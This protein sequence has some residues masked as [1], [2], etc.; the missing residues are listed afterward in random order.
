M[1]EVL[2]VFE[3]FPKIPRFNKA[4]ECVIT[5][6]IDGTNA[7]LLIRPEKE[8]NIDETPMWTAEVE[9]LYMIDNYSLWVHVPWACHYI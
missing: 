1:D 8:Y 3:P 2:N 5:E 4:G 6:K 9:G 7:Q